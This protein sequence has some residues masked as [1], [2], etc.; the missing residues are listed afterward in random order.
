MSFIKKVREVVASDKF[1]EFIKV[2]G[3]S[4]KEAYKK[5]P[6]M[7]AF[8]EGEIPKVL[9]RMTEAIKKGSYNHDGKAFQMTAKK[10][11]IKYTRK[12]IE[13]FLGLRK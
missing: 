4:L 13:E 1:E 6:E 12:A 8:P 9:E 3:D 10:L 2:Y 5:Y 11:G 7:Y